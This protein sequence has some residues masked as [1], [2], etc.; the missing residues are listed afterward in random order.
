MASIREQQDFNYAAEGRE[1]EVKLLRALALGGK[2]SIEIQLLLDSQA[3]GQAN[4][5]ALSLLLADVSADE[6]RAQITFERLRAHQLRLAQALGRPVG[7]KSA[8]MDYLENIELALALKPDEQALTY[9]QLAQMAFR[10]DLT[11]LANYR[12]FLRRFREEIKRADRY[13]HLLSSIMLDIDLFKMFNDKHG[14]LAGNK[15]LEHLAA[16]LR[17]EVRET[18]LVARYGGEEFVVI[19]PETTK[20]E[21]RELA[22]RI[23]ARVAGT[24]VEL[25]ASISCG[26]LQPVAP[27]AQR[28]TISLGVATYPRDARTAETLLASADE[29]LYEAKKEGRNRTRVY[30][31][32]TVVRLTYAPL[33]AAAVRSVALV[34]DFN[35]WEKHVDQLHEEAEGE[36]AIELH[37]A[38]GRYT[39]KFVIN[40]EWYVADPLCTEYTVDGYGGRN[41]VLLVK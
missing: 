36:Y 28:F 22:E 12:Y 8:A 9:T 14:H 21:A 6:K 15:A 10:D 1:V 26:T 18:D 33:D 25:P 30:H 5:Q 38:P 31:P 24:P 23:R 19:L 41:S 4:Y 2:Q 20:F 32:P 40:G 3:G 11:G 37:L 34:A 27:L 13:R 35:G 39:Y 29:A 17:A 7:I 16:L